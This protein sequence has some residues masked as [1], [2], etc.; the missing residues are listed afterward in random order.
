M[1][2]Y[3]QI[4]HLAVI[5]LCLGVFVT[6]PTW[7]A[8]RANHWL[9]LAVD[10]LCPIQDLIGYDAQTALQGSWLLDEVKAPREG[11]PK[12]IEL[13]LAVEGSG[14]LLVE[15]RFFGGQLSQFRATY[16]SWR[17]ANLQPLSMVIADGGC[18]IRSGR[19]LRIGE[20]V[21]QYLDHLEDDLETLRW[22]ETLQAPWPEG[23]DPGGARVALVDS[24]LAYDLEQFRNH[25]ARD[26]EGRS[27]GYDFWDMDP[28]PYD[29]DTSRGAF[30]PI[31]HGTPV[32]SI[33]VREAPD[34]A[35]IPFRYPRPDM[36]RMAQL[37]ERASAAGARIL[38]MPLG[39]RNPD[40]WRAF[41]QALK[42][43]DLL[44]I[45]SAGNDGKDIDSSPVYPASLSLENIITVTSADQFGRLASGS[46]WG[47]QS[48]DIMV[49][50]ENIDVVDFRG[51]SGKASGSS[52]AVPRIAA[53]AAR[54]LSEDP[55]LS[56]L[57]LKQQIFSRAAP[58]PFESSGKL[59]VGW[60]ADPTSD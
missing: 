22:S 2:F 8:E 12:R 49:P 56:V 57:E 16:S 4:H 47:A 50:A 34:A 48:V 46:N 41:E 35:L 30:L 53:L 21:W 51:A 42:R 60:I 58:S 40:Q 14:E 5:F 33:I 3:L 7:G 20:G 43:H 27:F 25:L 36:T 59:A 24:G 45:V 6:S 23:I 13:R 52:Y 1:Y 32:A 19:Q 11:D 37:V 31:R 9:K 54:I 39:S 26:Q 10:K 55:N 15:K 44:A 38:A 17:G 29:S 18:M 28:W